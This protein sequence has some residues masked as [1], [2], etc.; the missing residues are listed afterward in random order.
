MGTTYA[1]R[2]RLGDV[3]TSRTFTATVLCPDEGPGHAV[4]VPFDAV[5]VFGRARAPVV[6]TVSGHEPF[7]TTIASYGGTG[8]IG[9]RKAQRDD[10]MVGE[11]DEITMT[12]ELDEVPRIAEVPP[13]LAAALASNLEATIAFESLS[14]SHTREYAEWVGGAKRPITRE[15]RAEQAIERILKSARPTTKARKP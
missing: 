11:G 6:V 13:E 5:E 8:W 2:R 4:A 7:R 14:F 1:S 10:L 9:L 3:V 15:R 12:V